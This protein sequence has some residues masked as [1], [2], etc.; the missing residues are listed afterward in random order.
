MDETL[1]ANA[2]DKANL[3]AQG[4]V[5][6]MTP[7][8]VYTTQICGSVPLYGLFLPSPGND[9]FYT[10]ETKFHSLSKLRKLTNFDISIDVGEEL[11]DGIRI[12]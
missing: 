11:C 2:N 4:Y 10:S 3:E 8:F 9:H 1:S 5:S 12:H 7:G 6:E